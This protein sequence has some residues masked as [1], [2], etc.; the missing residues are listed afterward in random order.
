MLLQI[1]MD[2]ESM[3]HFLYVS[4]PKKSLCEFLHDFFTKKGLSPS[5]LP[6]SARRG[7][8]SY[9]PTTPPHCSINSLQCASHLS[10]LSRHHNPCL[11]QHVAGTGRWTPSTF[12]THRARKKICPKYL[13]SIHKQSMPISLFKYSTL[14]KPIT[15]TVLFE[16]SI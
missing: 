13:D 11:C 6:N 4:H 1:C 16:S 15:P 3:A 8:P 7:R 2:I 14:Q 10:F 5:S 12:S 9:I